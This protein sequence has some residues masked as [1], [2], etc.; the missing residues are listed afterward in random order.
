MSRICKVVKRLPKLARGY[1]FHKWEYRVVEC[2]Q[3]QLGYLTDRGVRLVWTSEPCTYRDGPKDRGQ[4]AEAERR[5]AL[6]NRALG[7]GLD[8][9]APEYAI[10]DRE[11]DLGLRD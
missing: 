4:R 3:D 6:G 11:M 5:A 8:P 2:D 7:V 9:D 1:I 10:H